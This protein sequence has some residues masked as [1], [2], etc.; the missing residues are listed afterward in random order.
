MASTSDAAR[1][2]VY[3]SLF[4]TLPGS[5]CEGVAF[6]IHEETGAV[7][8]THGPDPAP[9][10]VDVRS[11]RSLATLQ[12]EARA[13]GPAAVPCIGNG[14]SGRRVEA[15]YAVSSDH[16]DRYDAIAPLIRVWASYT[17]A[18]IVAASAWETGGSRAVR[19][20]TDPSCQLVVD[21]VVLSPAADDD[22]GTTISELRAMGYVAS[23]RKYMVWMDAAVVC[24]IAQFYGDDHDGPSNLSNGSALVQ[25]EVE[26][27][28]SGCWGLGGTDTPVEAHELLHTLGSVQNSAPNSTSRFP[29][30]PGAHCTD[31]HDTMCYADGPGVVIDIVCTDPFHERRL[32]CGHDD[33]FSTSPAPGSYLDTHW[34][35][36]D[37]SFL[38]KVQPPVVTGLRPAGAPVGKLVTISGVGFTGVTSVA[39][40]GVFQPSFTVVDDGTITGQG[41]LGRAHRAALRDRHAGDRL[42][43]RR[44]QGEAQGHRVH[45]RQRLARD[46]H[47]D[48]RVGVHRGDRR[49]VRVEDRPVLGPVLHD[50]LGHRSGRGC[51]R[52]DHGHHRGR[53]RDQRRRLR[54][55]LIRIRFGC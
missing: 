18:D 53:G 9:P 52:A 32:D 1:G 45:A 39:F 55:H 10:G 35:S 47:H 20:V 6:E 43:P 40:G 16:V 2:L 36:A 21:H 4:P 11:P 46:E 15:I 28:D 54:R 42:Q 51:D 48:Q 44:V 5:P 25:G 23:D 37:N 8:C 31:D 19:F 41:P 30:S 17:V 3:T 38:A 50:D 13:L 7:S 22:F 29:E 12:A 27:T 26:R 14:T 24:G 49:Q 33:Y 34:N